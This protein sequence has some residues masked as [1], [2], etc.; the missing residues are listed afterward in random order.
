[1]T[2]TTETTGPESS[3]GPAWA[4]WLGA[5]AIVLGVYLT[6]VHGN[7]W[8]TQYVMS[9]YMPEGAVPAAVCPEAELEEEGIEVEECEY[10]LAQVYGLDASTPDWFPGAYLILAGIG[11]VL[12]FVSVIVGGA[13][14]NYQSWAPRAAMAVFALLAAVDLFQFIAVVETGP[15]IRQLYLT[16]VLLWFLLH[17]LMLASAIAG[18]HGQ[19]AQRESGALPSTPSHG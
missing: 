5:I 10:L 8:M 12:A 15:I 6:A 11:T 14:V 9:N 1:M 19:N 3:T 7:E 16:N 18:Y 4:S 17:L 2:S 13:L